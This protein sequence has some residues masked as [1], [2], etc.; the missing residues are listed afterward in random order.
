M[1]DRSSEHVYNVLVPN[2]RNGGNKN[3]PSKIDR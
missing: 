3:P 1:L 2:K